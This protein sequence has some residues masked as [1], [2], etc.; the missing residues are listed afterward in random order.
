MKIF[1]KIMKDEARKKKYCAS[2]PTGI[3]NMKT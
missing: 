2:T 3:V 1:L